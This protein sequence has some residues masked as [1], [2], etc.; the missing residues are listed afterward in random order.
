V[1]EARAARLVAP[2]VA[3]VS[4][5]LALDG[6]ELLE[7]GWGWALSLVCMCA[8]LVLIAT[9]PPSRALFVGALTRFAVTQRSLW[10]LRAA[11]VATAPIAGLGPVAY[12]LLALGQALTL[13]PSEET[14]PDWRHALGTG[15]PGLAFVL[16]A[17]QL[18]LA[19]P[20][21]ELLWAILAGA[22]A[23][24]GFWWLGG[25]SPAVRRTVGAV[26]A[27]FL[28]LWGG[29]GVG[30][31]DSRGAGGDRGCPACDDRLRSALAAQFPGRR[32]RARADCTLRRARG[33]RRRRPRLGA[34]DARPDPEPSRRSERGEGAGARS[35]TRPARPSVR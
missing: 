32:D 21:D 28:L 20:D 11:T 29:F 1:T 17:E 13:P 8:G 19:V 9:A 5:V 16:A 30:D 7:L 2:A 34:P 15:L 26:V 31:V 6:A 14:R 33:G 22:T 35:G 23:L 12:A 25:P 3:L 4:V 18:G 10:T 27:F 24:S